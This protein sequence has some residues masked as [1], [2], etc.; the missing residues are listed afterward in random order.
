[1]K[2]QLKDRLGH[3]AVLM[4]IPIGLEDKHEGVV[5][6]VSMESVYFDGNDGEKVRIE[7]IPH[8]LKD[9]ADR[10]REEMLDAVSMFSDELMEAVR[11]GLRTELGE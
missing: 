4:Q 11:A 7:E 10:S 5:D 8:E 2:N 1:V 9:Q 6:L 3:N